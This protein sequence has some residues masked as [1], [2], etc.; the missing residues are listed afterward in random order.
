MSGS[1]DYDVVGAYYEDA[2]GTNAG[3]AYIFARFGTTWTQQQKLAA[4]DGAAQDEFGN[5]VSGNEDYAV[6]GA[7][8]EDASGTNAGAAYIFARFGTTWTQ[9]QKLIGSD[10]VAYD[11][12]GWSLATSGDYIVVGAKDKSPWSSGAAYMFARS[13]TSWTQ[14]QR[15]YGSDA[16]TTDKFGYA[17]AINGDYVL[18]SSI[19]QGLRDGAAYIYTV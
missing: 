4:S 13:G 7:Y 11:G 16:T 10:I 18:V 12:F 1:G 9:Q 8:H 2:S 19:N 17:V 6:V 5:S 3:A 14:Q 15:L